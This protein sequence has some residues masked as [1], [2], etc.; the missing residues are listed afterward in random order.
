MGSSF[1]SPESTTKEGDTAILHITRESQIPVKLS[2]NIA[3]GQDSGY[4]EGNVINTK[5]GSFPHSTLIGIPW[6]SQV[7]ASKVDTGTRGRLDP[8][9]AKKK[10]KAAEISADEPDSDLKQATTASSGFVHVLPPTPEGWTTSLP[11]RTQV[12]YTPDYSYVL[13]R[14]RAR[15]GTV[16]IEAGSG[17][18]SFTHAAARAVFD[19]VIAAELEAGALHEETSNQPGHVYTFEYHEERQVKVKEEMAEHKI[20]NIVTSTHRD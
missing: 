12:V 7:L 1:F 19:G 13:H 14:V 9:I 8:S 11:H 10:R 4:A 16:L 2:R 20:D 5:F 15:P 17:S 18:G 6:G 3:R